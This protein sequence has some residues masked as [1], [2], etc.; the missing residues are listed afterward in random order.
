M[1]EESC[2][3]A[4]NNGQTPLMLAQEEGHEDVENLFIERIKA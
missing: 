3:Q 4:N 1:P 2:N